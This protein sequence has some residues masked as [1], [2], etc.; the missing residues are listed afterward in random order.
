MMMSNADCMGISRLMKNEPNII[1]MKMKL[2]MVALMFCTGT[3]AE[4]NSS[5]L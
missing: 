1:A 3:I 2:R 4:R 5:M